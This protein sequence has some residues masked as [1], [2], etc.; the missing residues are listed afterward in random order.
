MNFL[1]SESRLPAGQAGNKIFS[2]MKIIISLIT[3]LL[4]A[5]LLTAQDAGIT[6]VDISGAPVGFLGMAQDKYGY[7]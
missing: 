1:L 3:F 7:I 5:S 6:P 4:M 2:K